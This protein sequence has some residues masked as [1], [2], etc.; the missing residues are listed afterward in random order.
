MNRGRFLT[1]DGGEGSGK[2]TQAH[3]LRERL[4]GAGIEAIVTR[5][6][7]G[8]P[9]AEDIRKLLVS[10]EAGR[11]QPLTEALLHYAARTEHIALSIRPALERGVWVISDRFADSTMA[12]QGIAMDA[13]RDTVAAV[14]AAVLGDFAPDL[15]LVLDVDPETGV[16]RE[17]REGGEDRYGSMGLE[18]HRKVRDGFR[19]IAAAEPERCRLIDASGTVDA[20][21]GLIWAATA[22]RFGL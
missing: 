2:T 15:T 7:G 1:F 17:T 21:G 16:G 22:D 5:E 18:F 6:P 3:R 14:A 9:R 13:G 11:W 20:V 4:D 10:G 19:E 12:Y 8:T